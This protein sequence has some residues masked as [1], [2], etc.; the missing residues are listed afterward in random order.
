MI[1]L[2]KAVFLTEQ[3]DVA[4]LARKCLR[5][6]G[7]DCEVLLGTPEDLIEQMAEREVLLV[8]TPNKLSNDLREQMPVTIIEVPTDYIALFCSI[9]RLR[10]QGCR[11][12][13]V[14][15]QCI[16]DIDW[17]SRSFNDDCQVDFIKVSSMQ[18][19][20]IAVGEAV[21]NK[22][23]GIIAPP[24]L[25]SRLPE[26]SGIVGEPMTV[27]A[28]CLMEIF[29]AAKR[30]MHLE[31]VKRLQLT[32]LDLLIN[33]IAEGV[34]IFNRD[35]EAVF[36]NVQADRILHGIKESDYYDLMAPLFEKTQAVNSVVNL[37]GKQ[38][39]MHSMHFI[40]P[41]TDIDNHVVILHEGQAIE[42]S[43]RSL[44]SHAINKGLVAKATFDSLV[45]QDEK[46]R[47]SIEQAK[48]FARSDSTVLICG[49]TGVG[50]EMFAQSIH[51][52]SARKAEPF[53]SVNC[54]VLP[55]S[56]IES[57]LFGYVE[58]A[59]T[60]ARSQGKRGLFELAHKGTI[61]L[62]EIGELPLDIQ[63]RL[64]R[65]LQE[66]EIM[67]IGDDKVIPIDVRIICATNRHLWELSQEGKFRLDLYYRINV[68]RLR[69]A[70][71]RERPADIL[72]LF[73]T[74]LERF[75]G[76][77]DFTVDKDAE[78]F[79]LQAP[80]QGNI[81]ELRNV[82]EACVLDGPQVTKSTLQEIMWQGA[83]P[84]ERA[85]PFAPIGNFAPS[86]AVSSALPPQNGVP[87][88]SGY[89]QP[90]PNAPGFNGYNGWNGT[91]SGM[92]GMA[93][94]SEPVTAGANGEFTL[95]INPQEITS[96]KDLEKQ[97]LQSMLSCMSHEEVCERLNL[98]RVTLWRKLKS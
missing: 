73:R 15:F 35:K 21:L 86:F 6:S 67:R 41:N 36:H 80:W 61:F 34:I 12:I 44:R 5:Q 79:L 97:A 51:N 60:G 96:L 81:R 19:G 94:G 39:L 56:L 43:E 46:T 28:T 75:F 11:R 59:F 83:M 93:P 57:E 72:P 13:F 45:A 65:V 48:R 14:I 10:R 42:K 89:A 54:A 17:H 2:S 87:A 26:R 9:D 88:G 49:E 32:R 58:G 76:N 30:I 78:E 37:N 52:A 22:V 98:S 16:D 38:V 47:A 8:I 23:D 7:F 18:E 66:R 82:A 31:K 69:I 1:V 53:V 84:G 77:K 27:S 92:P 25:L 95:H 40:F 90:Q 62:D 70:P 64:L 24:R 29:T 63:S 4:K 55:P 20:V 33:N 91:A 3:P 68:L 74:Y 71:L 85:M 50:K